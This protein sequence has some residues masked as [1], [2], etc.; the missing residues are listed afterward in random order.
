MYKRQSDALIRSA[1]LFPKPFLAAKKIKLAPIV[2]AVTFRNV[3]KVNPNK[4]PPVKD[5][6]GEPGKAKVTKVMYENIN[7]ITVSQ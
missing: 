5:A 7:N 4:K 1:I 2:A 6:I 3:P